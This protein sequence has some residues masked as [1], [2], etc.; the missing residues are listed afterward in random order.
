M[1]RV[2]EFKKQLETMNENLTSS[3]EK[4]QELHEK[5]RMLKELFKR[6]DQVFRICFRFMCD[7][8]QCDFILLVVN[9]STHLNSFMCHCC[10]AQ[11]DCVRTQSVIRQ[12][13]R[14]TTYSLSRSSFC[15]ISP[16]KVTYQAT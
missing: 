9:R 3:S 13:L 15:I 12:N 1:L 14:H 16:L 2:D 11:F 4:M 10:C 6:I 5:M 8:I 7:S